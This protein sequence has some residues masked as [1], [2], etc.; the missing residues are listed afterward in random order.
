MLL[1]RFVP[2][3]IA[4]LLVKA[5]KDR[6]RRIG[7]S[8]LAARCTAVRSVSTCAGSDPD[9]SLA[10]L[11]EKNLGNV[12]QHVCACARVARRGLSQVH[13]YVP[14]FAFALL[15]FKLFSLSMHVLQASSSI[16]PRSPFFVALHSLRGAMTNYSIANCGTNAFAMKKR[17]YLES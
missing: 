15:V 8:R 14:T 11:A 1:V 10:S 12:Q 7:F 6:T 5:G 13:R 17:I 3:P 4:N 9:V 16:S 2:R